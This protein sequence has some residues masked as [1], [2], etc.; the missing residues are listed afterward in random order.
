MQLELLRSTLRA[1]SSD[2]QSGWSSGLEPLYQTISSWQT[3]WPPA[4]ADEIGAT[5][6]AALQ[7]DK[8]RTYWQGHAY[9]PKEALI[10]LDDYSPSMINLAFGRLFNEAEELGSRFSGFVFYLDEVLEEMRRT[11]LHRAP[12]TH[13]HD[14]YRAPSLYCLCRFPATHA[15][16]EADIYLQALRFLRAPN[17]G[18]IADPSR[19]AK[20]TKVIMTFLA[21]EPAFAKADAARRLAQH[22]NPLLPKSYE[23][24]CALAASEYFRWL[25]SNRAKH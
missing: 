10:K 13:Y 6:E 5:V 14:D 9:F 18:P 2:L 20:S 17:P 24:T 4:N 15:Y 22:R 7:N 19:F 25:N 8:T 3:A 1:F 21:Q 23:G 11:V 12:T 16:F